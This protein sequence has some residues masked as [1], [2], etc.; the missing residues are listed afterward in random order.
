MTWFELAETLSEELKGPK[1]VADRHGVADFLEWADRTKLELPLKR[2]ASDI[3]AAYQ[4]TLE[5]A[6]A[7]PRGMSKK[8]K[9]ARAMAE[10][11][12]G[13]A[14]KAEVKAAEAVAEA[15]ETQTEEQDDMPKRVQIEEEDDTSLDGIEEN[16]V[17]GEVEGA[18]F[19]EV[20]PEPEEEP[21]RR[22]RAA[23]RIVVQVPQARR[24]PVSRAEARSTA[25]RN[26]L[27]RTEK[28]RLYKRD[29]VGKRQLI[30]DY[31]VDEIGDVKLE[32]FLREYVD[33][34]FHN[35]TG[36]TEYIAYELDARTGREKQPPST[37]TIRSSI[38]EGTPD[39]F[40]QVRQAMG[41]INELQQVAQPNPTNQN[42]LLKR[43]QH[44]A[45]EKG[46]MNSMM[47][48][49]MMERF[50]GGSSGG[51]N[52]G[53][54]LMKVLDRLEKVERGERRGSP[55]DFGPPMG[56]NFGAFP[57]PPMYMPPPP[58]PPAPSRDNSID[59]VVELA[60]AKL[61]Q[62]TPPLSE[63]VKE[64]MTLRQLTSPAE[65]PEVAAL[66]AELAALRAQ[67][68]SGGSKAS[69]GIED[70]LAN[71]EKF[72]TIVKSV[73]P[74]VTG[75][76]DEGGFLKGLFTSDVGKVLG[77]VIA[78]A[79]TAQAQQTVQ[80]QPQQPQQP[81]QLQA[82]PQPQ[83]QPSG[84]PPP[85][86]AVM[87]AVR[88]FGI[89][90]TPEVQAQKF[91]DVLFAMYTSGLPHYQR[92]LNPALEALNRAEE[93][94]KALDVPR[95]TAMSLIN[96]MR[97]PLATPDFVDRCIAALAMRAGV[98]QLPDTLVKTAGKWTMDYSGNVLLLEAVGA[99]PV[100]AE[101][102]PKPSNGSHPDA[103]Q[104]PVTPIPLKD[105]V[106]TAPM[107][108]MPTPELSP[109]VEVPAKA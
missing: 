5:E 98:S 105:V 1:H 90:Q 25:V 39:A 57:P 11:L 99:K 63:Q 43:A 12:L 29:E 70:S 88:A 36:V 93:S 26:I 14:P 109:E 23:P 65:S 56:G 40:G 30:E 24:N 73:A 53:D 4:T 13:L 104:T 44:S 106:D 102:S 34:E 33:P 31:S 46:D 17:E 38:P 7:G 49:M 59:K 100:E 72:T 54:L 95:R 27:P 96:E 3:L 51:N 77:D 78:K 18:E 6:Y 79:A 103:V 85:P 87:D 108:A 86:P 47:M 101:E 58:P 81:Q 91:V 97:P 2:E 61:V 66:K 68:S 69:S 10:K 16:E 83:P 62:P 50:M 82:A 107:T 41:L 84:P 76:S 74:Q 22:K 15:T 28:I 94:V 67:V 42:E 92:I 64:M 48:L 55:A 71:F 20:E 8:G 35:D 75:S 21:R 45:V 9:A 52:T 60:V 89:A 37:L 80:A 19:D 32:T